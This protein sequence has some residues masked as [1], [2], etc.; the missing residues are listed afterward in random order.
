MTTP[1][2]H[3]PAIEASGARVK[4]GSVAAIDDVSFSFPRGAL[5]GLVGPNGGGKSTLL[6]ALVGLVG[7]ES[8]AVR[9]IG[10]S[11]LEARRSV[12]YVPQSEN[13]NWHFPVTVRQVVMMGRSAKKNLF[14]FATRRDRKA[15]DAALERVQLW[16]RRNDPIHELS[17]GQRQRAFVARALAVNAEVLLLDEAFSGV[18]VASQNELVKVL[19]DIC[20]EGRTVMLSTH[21]LTNL[22]RSFDQ[23]LCLNCHVCACGPPNK[24]F[25][26]AVLEELY[27][28]HGIAFANH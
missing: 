12:G 14:G 10:K 21:D 27:G 24:T 11:P 16:G 20:T 13:V 8:G 18:D 23:V 2:L 7:L 3:V 1:N 22:A 9:V 17:G 6:R 5:V 28:A 19:R 15:V 26:P 4:Y 25:T